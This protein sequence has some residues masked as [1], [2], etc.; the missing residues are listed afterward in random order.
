MEGGGADQKRRK[1]KW[2][3]S[4]Y[5]KMT[6][7]EAQM[8]L[9]VR[10]TLRGIQ[11]KQMLEGKRV[12]LDKNLIMEAKR[13]VYRGLVRPLEAGGYP[14][15]ADPDFKE[16]N[17]NDLAA[18]TIYPIPSLF[19]HETSR[20]LHLS[21][22]KEIASLDSSTSGIEEFVVLDYISLEQTKYILIVE[23]KKVSLGE[24]QKQCFLSMKDMRDSNGGGI[25]YGFITM[26]DSWRMAS[27]DGEFKISEKIELLFDTMAEMAEDKERWME[28]YSI[29]VDCFNVALST[30]SNNLDAV[31]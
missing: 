5:P 22:E 19:K 4:S 30:G 3:M 7:E 23:A 11:V 24:V 2:T 1:S 8:R 21:R 16:A 25:V 12:L 9:N 26:S 10:L 29:L 20:N 13:E 27:F 28:N 17:I 18:F 14:S 15:E 31:V 6:I